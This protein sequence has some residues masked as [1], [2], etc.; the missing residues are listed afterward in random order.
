MRVI[1]YVNIE[2]YNEN[3]EW[4]L[5]FNFVI[6]IFCIE[7]GEMF[8]IVNFVLILKRCFGYYLLQIIF[9]IFVISFFINIIFLLF[10]DFG[11][12]IFFI[13]IVFLFLV[14]LL[15][16]IG[17]SMLII[18]RYILIFCMLLYNMMFFCLD[19]LKKLYLKGYIVLIIYKL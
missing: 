8:F 6:E 14:V 16:L 2:D 13:L 5:Y 1:D 19:V 17:D 11:E 3:G 15:M 9:L 18:F 7:E 4:V 12:K 10:M